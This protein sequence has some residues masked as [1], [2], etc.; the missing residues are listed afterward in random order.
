VLLVALAWH[1]FQSVRL[2]SSWSA[3]LD[4]NQ[5]VMVVDHAIHLYHGALGSRFLREH[6][7]TWGFDP[8]FMAGYPETPVWDSSS[9]LS[10]AFQFAAGGGY[11]PRAYK[12]GLLACTLLAVAL[13]PA[14]A[15][16]TGLGLSE[17]AATAMLGAGLF[18]A[19]MPAILWRTGLFS[20]V[21]AAAM[22][23]VVIGLLLRF[24]QNPTF[25]RWCALAA[26]GAAILFVH[27]TAPI[28]VLGAGVGYL[29]AAV[30]SW[31]LRRRSL[32]AV[33]LAAT[34]AVL[35]NAFWLIPLWRFRGIRAPSGYFMTSRSARFLWDYYVVNPLDG[36]VS[37]ALLVLGVIGVVLWWV[38]GERVRAA[39]YS[40]AI[41]VFLALCSAGGLWSVTRATE[42]FRFLVALD[43]LLTIPASSAVV[44]AAAWL[45]R[46][47]DGWRGPA[48][49]S[50]VA[51]LITASAWLVSPATFRYGFQFA[52]Q[53]RPLVIG[54]RPEDEQL[55]GWLRDHTDLSAR[56]LFEDQLRLL[57]ST[58]PE[59]T[60]WTPLLPLLLR[61]ERRAFIGGL[62][63]TAF[64]RHH[65]TASFGDYVLGP[66]RI[67]AWPSHELA[68]YCDRYNVGWVVCWSPLSRFWF[69]GFS[70]ARLVGTLPRPASPGREVMRDQ[71][72]WDAIA[73]VAGPNAATRYLNEGVNHYYVYALDRPHSYFLSGQ[74]RLTALDANRVEFADV[75]P[76]AATG[77]AV[78][79]LHWLDHWKADPPV[80]LAATT[81]PGDP[82]P[83]VR[84][85]TGRTLSRVVLS[86]AY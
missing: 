53:H 4:D 50:V 39:T 12:L 34:S 32:A 48:L 10:I 35:V 81:I 79:S 41:A 30:G 43:L 67:D 58:D 2:F 86:N 36:R 56:V 78:V 75:V 19:A 65:Q 13:L 1:A 27:V 25:R 74:G 57:E 72:Q 63:Q 55:V 29:A 24:D 21:T 18:W 83:F 23:G 14:G 84:I 28:L 8:F 85:M 69:D 7:T 77:A 5:P 16:A 44:R 38:E 11:S 49:A 59:S 52:T 51:A 31:R 37:L 47:A 64:I 22:L 76:D 61:P 3:L 66:R 73:R 46:R 70:H 40:G 42:P 71:A 9:N 15:R 20:F 62:Y 80:P 33:A 54:L 60:H 17:S 68:G 82:V 45:S 26:A 6:A